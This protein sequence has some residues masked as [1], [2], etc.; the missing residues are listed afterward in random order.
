[1][2]NRL[3]ASGI[4]VG[5]LALA[6]AAA[7]AQMALPVQLGVSGGAAFP[8]AD[9]GRNDAVSTG[10]GFEVNATLQVAPGIGVYAAYDRYG[11]PFDT[12][13]LIDLGQGEG[14]IVDQG[15][16]GGIRLGIPGGGF[17]LNPW[18]RGGAIYNSAQFD[19]DTVENDPESESGLGFEVGG[20]LDFPLGFVV[21][22]T[23]SVRYRSYKPDFGESSDFDISYIV[24]ELGLTFRF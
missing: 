21:S 11:F 17:G 2:R 3:F 18:V 23:P 15:F 20:G 22:V 7:G 9:L 8:M 5:A 19:Y 6:P 24:G 14:E 10:W 1:M 12:D 4:L 16:A 13:P